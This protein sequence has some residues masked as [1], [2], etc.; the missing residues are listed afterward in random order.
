MITYAYQA[1]SADGKT[2]SGVTD[3]INEDNAINVLMGRGLMVL[4]LEEQASKSSGR[5]AGKVTS[6]DLVLFTR[7]LATMVDAG[8]PLLTGLTALYEQCDSPKQ[9]GLRYIVGEVMA[10][11]QEGETFHEAV[12]KHPKVFSRLFIS[13]VRA[14]ET[15]GMLAE[16]LDRLA[17]FLESSARLTKKVKSAMTYPVVVI[18]IALGITTFLIIKVVPAFGEIFS[19]FGSKLPAPTQFLIDVSHFVRNYWIWIVGVIGGGA[20]AI[21]KFLETQAGTEFWDRYKLRLPVV[22]PLTHKICMSRFART[23]AQ[24]IR[25]GVPILEVM[26]IVGETSGNT[27]VEKAIISVSADVEKGDGLAAAMTRQTIFPPVMLRMV[28]AG[29]AT[30]KIDVMLEKIADFWDEEI[31][32]MLDALTSL[33]EPFLI[34][35]LG[36]V[37]G[38]IVIAMFLPIF[39]LSDVVSGTGK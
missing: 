29:E 12:S 24:L 15:G 23:F 1:R 25:A 2:V 33:I 19:D 6:S 34:V 18:C 16:I 8:L 30:G 31:D 9:A 4:S 32:A 17:G 20:Y 5:K 35:F 39:K 22:G 21:H 28:S 7:Q 14:G 36:V 27:M 13:M 11:V 37:V 3:A 38:G 26:A 10:R